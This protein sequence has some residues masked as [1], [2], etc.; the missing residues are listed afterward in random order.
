MESQPVIFQEPPRIPDNLSDVVRYKLESKAYKTRVRSVA[1]FTLEIIGIILVIG[2]L[3]INVNWVR[4]AV[5]AIAIL[6]AIVLLI[7]ISYIL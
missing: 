2:L 4:A 6:I 1:N 7:A 3:W 5:T